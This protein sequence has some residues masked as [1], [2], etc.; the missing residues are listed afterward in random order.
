MLVK[1]N[2][3]LAPYVTFRIGGSTPQMIVPETEEELISLIKDFKERKEKYYLLGN[4]SNVLITDNNLSRKVILNKKACDYIK[5]KDKG[6]V[7]VGSSVDIRNLI[8]RLIEHNLESFVALYTI[9]ATVGGAIFQNASRNSFKVGISDN[10]IYVRYF[11]GEVIR[12]ISKEECQFSW[13][14]SIFHEHRNWVILS[15]VFQF[16]EQPKEVGKERRKAST[17]AASN[18]SYRKHHSAGS[19]FKIKCLKILEFLK[20]IRLGDAEFSPTTVNTIHNL[21]KAKFKDVKR[22]IFLAKL[23]HKICLK[24]VELEIEIW[25]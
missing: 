23:V 10:L 11:D 19:V 18:K 15:A 25:E 7:E 13:R 9:P 4:G 6:I 2:E 1:E 8:D 22:L 5:F 24:K 21:G 17:K 3:I 16:N 12:T 14:H 20:G